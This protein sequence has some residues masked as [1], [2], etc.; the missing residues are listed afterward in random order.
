MDCR[1]HFCLVSQICNQRKADRIFFLHS[2]NIS[3]T[4][5]RCNNEM[6][7][8]QKLTMM[9]ILK[10]VCEKV[11]FPTISRDICLIKSLMET[12]CCNNNYVK[13]ENKE[14]CLNDRCTTFKMRIL[15]MK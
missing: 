12:R 9:T 5:A 14:M 15:Y 11:I 1:L 10:V 3:P 6:W 7:F 8:P 13:L 4:Q 2:T